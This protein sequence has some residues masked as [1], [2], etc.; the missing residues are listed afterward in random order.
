MHPIL[1][2]RA[3]LVLYVAAWLPLAGLLA[4]LLVLQIRFSWPQALL[5][6]GPL[7]LLYALLCLPSWY[8]CRAFPAGLT[9]QAR[10]LAAQLLAA[11]FSG[12]LWSALGI[13]WASLLSHFSGNPDYSESYKAAIPLFFAM[14]SVIYVAVA[15]VH[16]LLIAWQER[17]EA[18]RLVLEMAVMAR[19]AELKALKM[20]LAPHF[21]FNSLNS[22]SALTGSS[23][24]AAREMCLLLGSFLRKSLAFGAKLQVTLSEEMSL[25]SDFLAIER[26]RFGPRL[27]LDFKVQEQAGTC[28]MPPLLLQPLLENAV[29]HG[30]AQM[31][32]G[33]TIS[34][35]ASLNGSRLSIIITNPYDPDSRP[36]KGTGL[37]LQNVRARLE[38]LFGT[39][40]RLEVERDAAVFRVRM[41]LPVRRSTASLTDQPP[42]TRS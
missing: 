21:L 27:S 37:G 42:A 34:L 16:Y 4:A 5:V 15:F 7:T 29:N 11:L 30:V 13:P 17:A 33:G 8:L 9:S 6:A 2:N 20:Q 40:A 26:V 12:L 35:E 10:L 32:E 31:I 18:D 36:S 14:G 38:T 41:L 3:R 1:S 24:K 39:E 19:E 23:P 25:V 28:L 22:I